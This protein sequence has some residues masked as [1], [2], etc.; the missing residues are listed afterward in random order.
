MPSVQRKQSNNKNAIIKFSP[1]DIAKLAAELYNKLQ[2]LIQDINDSEE[3]ELTLPLFKIAF[4]TS[5]RG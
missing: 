4:K 5:N 1:E 2:E 3:I